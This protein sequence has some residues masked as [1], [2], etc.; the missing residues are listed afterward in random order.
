MKYFHDLTEEEFYALDQHMTWNQVATEYLQPTWCKFPDPVNPMG[1][2][3]LIYF[4]V[5]K[6]GIYC[7][8]CEFKKD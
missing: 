2:W 7:K 1:C 4:L 5:D 3:G 8:D 6:E